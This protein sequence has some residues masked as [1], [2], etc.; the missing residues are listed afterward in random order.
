MKIDSV[1]RES[2]GL[3]EP[4][5]SIIITKGNDVV[6]EKYYGY[7]DIGNNEKLNS[8]HTLYLTKHQ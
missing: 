4:G 3:K 7:A 6:F 5:L 1:L 8:Q 2:V